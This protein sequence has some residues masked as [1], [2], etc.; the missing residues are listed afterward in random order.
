MEPELSTNVSSP[1]FTP[2]P[3]VIN[4]NTTTHVSSFNQSNATYYLE[5]I[6]LP[7]TT[8]TLFGLTCFIAILGLCG[9]F[10]ILAFILKMRSQLKG[11]DV[12]TTVLAAFDS[13]A[14]TT[15][16][17]TT[18]YVDDVIGMDIT[19][20][21][22]IGC[23]LFH[24]VFFSA[25][26]GSSLVVVLICIE[27]FLA[28]WFPLRSRILLSPTTV[29]RCV[30]ICL[31]PMVL[32]YCVTS[33]LYCELDEDGIC[34][35]NFDGSQ[36]STVLKKKPN[37]IIYN[38]LNAI[39][40]ICTLVILPILTPLTIFKLFKHAASRRHLTTQE[41]DSRH[42]QASVKLTAVV[43]AQLTLVGLPACIGSFLILMD[44]D[45]KKDSD[46]NDLVLALITLALLLNHSM[47][48]I[49]YN[50]FDRDFRTKALGLICLKKEQGHS[51]VAQD[52][53]CDK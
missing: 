9:N 34:N 33:V 22:S 8:Y 17:F 44:T 6:P 11:H 16:P 5:N 26:Y 47:N 14:I 12:L 38:I 13:F 18:P 31:T 30:L 36:F 20:L 52:V 4:H 27:R 15:V 51:N 50:I 21:S 48:F 32:A 40:S 46:K 45:T 3:D 29:R 2:S 24:A 10:S 49:L 39:P 53:S 23:K 25:I 37:T 19:A 35:P 41:Q 42:Y 7:G 1:N 43:V 28:V